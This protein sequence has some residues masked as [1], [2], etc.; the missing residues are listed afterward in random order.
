[1]T[2]VLEVS[3]HHYRTIVLRR[4]DPVTG[5][6]FKP[7]L[8]YDGQRERT[9]STTGADDCWGVCRPMCEDCRSGPLTCGDYHCD[10][11]ETAA[12]C[13]GDCPI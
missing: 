4:H 8:V 11:P 3:A 2:R 5:R 1:V 7:S 6:Y 12:S 10:P 9:Q 13:P